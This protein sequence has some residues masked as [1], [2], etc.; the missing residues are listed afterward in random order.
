MRASEQGHSPARVASPVS[1]WNK[2]CVRISAP[3]RA[4]TRS[5]MSQRMGMKLEAAALPSVLSAAVAHATEGVV[6]GD[7]YVSSLYSTVNF[8]GLSNLSVNANGTT[9][10]QFDL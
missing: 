6:V 2:N 4:V 10:I 7:T 1:E 8:G 9:L 3:M 5:P